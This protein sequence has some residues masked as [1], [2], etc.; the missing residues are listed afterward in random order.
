MGEKRKSCFTFLL[1]KE[2]K[3]TFKIE[4]FDSVLWS[5]VNYKSKIKFRLRVNGKWFPYDKKD[6]HY[7]YKYEIRDLIFRNLNF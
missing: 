6:K 7:F 4:L 2:S 3:E 1:K 5:G